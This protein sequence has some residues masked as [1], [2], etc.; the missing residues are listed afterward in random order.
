ML[1]SLWNLIVGLVVVGF[2]FYL[3]V[4]VIMGF[5]APKWAGELKTEIHQ[6]MK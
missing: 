4:Y 6:E 2:L 5:P 3:V 1:K